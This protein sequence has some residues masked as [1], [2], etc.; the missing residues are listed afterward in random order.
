MSVLRLTSSTTQQ[1]FVIMIRL[2]EGYWLQPNKD[3]VTLFGSLQPIEIVNNDTTH[4]DNWDEFI[5]QLK[6]YFQLK[7][8]NDGFF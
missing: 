8:S 3:S 1:E 7:D 5:E 2:L 4:W 6:R